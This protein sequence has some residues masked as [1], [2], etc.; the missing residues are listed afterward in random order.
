MGRV[1]WNDG[2][3]SRFLGRSSTDI[4][5]QMPARRFTDQ[6]DSSGINLEFHRMLANPAHGC[7][8]V[9]CTGGLA[10]ISSLKSY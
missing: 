2:G 1:E 7:L 8:H 9:F 4:G 10:Q 3:Q 6:R 5:N